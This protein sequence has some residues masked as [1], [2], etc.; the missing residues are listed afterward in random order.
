MNHFLDS[1]ADRALQQWLATEAG[2][3][4]L[5]QCARC[6]ATRPTAAPVDEPKGD[7]PK[8][9]CRCEDCFHAPIVCEA[10]AVAMHASNPFHRIMQWS[11]RQRFWART[12]LDALGLVIR[13]GHGGT[14]C[15]S[16]INEPR[17]VTVVHAGGV[18]RMH[19][20]FCACP[21]R[22]GQL[23]QPE[24]LQLIAFGLWPGSW[25]RPMT[26]YTISVLKDFHLLSLQAQANAHDFVTYLRRRTNNIFPTLTPVREHSPA[27]PRRRLT[28]PSGSR[29]RILNRDEG[30]HIRQGG[31]TGGSG[32]ATRAAEERTGGVVPR[33][34]PTGHQ[35][36]QEMAGAREE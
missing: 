10:C 31:Q 15:I 12:T 14:G 5:A 36:G 8:G 9:W 27:Y 7:E 28:P 21:G 32:R 4:P 29:A 23:L 11:P 16:R 13:L 34:P 30:V 3:P 2:P 26:A 19:V 24:A 18:Q 20:A 22:D 35:H 6:Q 1:W 25:E 17:R 33:V